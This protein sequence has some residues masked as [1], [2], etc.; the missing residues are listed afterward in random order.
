MLFRRKEI[1]SIADNPAQIFYLNQGFIRLY[2]ISKEGNELTIH[3]FP[4]GSVFPI[5]LD[6]GTNSD[7]YYFE[8]LTPIEIYGERE[9]EFRQYIAQK[10]EAAAEIVQQLSGFSG[11]VI[12]KLQIKILG[13]ATQQVIAT[14]LDLADHLGRKEKNGI[15]ITYWFTHQDIASLAGL[16]RERVTIEIDNLLKKKLITYNSHFISIPKRELLKSEIE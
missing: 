2:T 1:V 15:V 7:Q 8:S 16:S 11:S 9:K 13:N 5:L 12:K 10:P 14:L 4:P 3:I 6:K